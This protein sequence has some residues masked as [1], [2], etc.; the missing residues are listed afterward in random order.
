MITIIGQRCESSYTAAPVASAMPDI[1]SQGNAP[2]ATKQQAVFHVTEWYSDDG[3]CLF[4]ARLRIVLRINFEGQL[5]RKTNLNVN[6]L[7][8]MYT[9]KLSVNASILHKNGDNYSYKPSWEN[10]K[11]V[12]ILFVFIPT[13]N[14]CLRMTGNHLHNNF[15]HS[16]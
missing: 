4:G 7:K 16:T 10:S 5:L 12:F 11:N 14:F 1:S 9:N 2:M 3:Y 6:A 13:W 8:P 15:I